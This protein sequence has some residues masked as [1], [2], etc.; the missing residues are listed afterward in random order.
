M[1]KRRK[2]LV[3]MVGLSCLALLAVGY[4]VAIHWPRIYRGPHNAFSLRYAGAWKPRTAGGVVTL[5]DA[6]A[7][8]GAGRSVS[9]VIA[10]TQPG[11]AEH[12]EASLGKAFAAVGSDYRFLKATTARLPGGEARIYSYTGVLGGVRR[13]N[14][15]YVFDMGLGKAAVMTCSAPRQQAA[16][17][18]D[19]CAAFAATFRAPGE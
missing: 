1:N 15:V 16:G 8:E 7:A 14:V 6:A 5:V 18:A 4:A 3:G 13:T 2:V 17:L 12:F 11:W 19:A 9:V 10:Q